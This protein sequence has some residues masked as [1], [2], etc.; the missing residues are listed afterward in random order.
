MRCDEYRAAA[1]TRRKRC[2]RCL[3]MVELRF[4]VTRRVKL[5]DMQSGRGGGTH[6]TGLLLERQGRVAPRDGGEL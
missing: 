4:F 3:E 2:C 1:A 5:C 6:Q